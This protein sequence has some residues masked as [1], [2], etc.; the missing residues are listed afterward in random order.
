MIHITDETYQQIT[1][2]LAGIKVWLKNDAPYT[3]KNSKVRFAYD[4]VSKSLSMLSSDI[5]A[6]HNW[7]ELPAK[8]D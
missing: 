7:I 2:T 1:A 3:H 6:K 4:E 8:K 5:E